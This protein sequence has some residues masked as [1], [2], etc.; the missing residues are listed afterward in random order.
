MIHEMTCR[1]TVRNEISQEK[2]IRPTERERERDRS[3][4]SDVFAEDQAFG[5]ISR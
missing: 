5:A 4:S 1:E 2:K 3:D